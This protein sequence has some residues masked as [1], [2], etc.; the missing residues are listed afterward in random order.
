MFWDA[1]S[2]K[3]FQILTLDIQFCRD[4]GVAL[5]YTHYIRRLQE[6]FAWM[7]YDG[8]LRETTC[9]KS[10]V[11]IQTSWPAEYDGR[12]LSEDEYLKIVN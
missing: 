6:N 4:L 11:P 9:A 1:I 12:I 2:H 10:G 7:P 5:P 8:T 3:P